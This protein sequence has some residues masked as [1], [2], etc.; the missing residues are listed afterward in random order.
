MS[1]VIAGVFWFSHDRR[2]A[3]KPTGGRWVVMLNLLFLL[4]II[5]LPVRNGLFS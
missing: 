2:L 4:A 5:L 1:F 3:R